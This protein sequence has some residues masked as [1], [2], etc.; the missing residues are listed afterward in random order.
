MILGRMTVDKAVN[1][2]F[3]FITVIN[4]IYIILSQTNHRKVCNQ[5]TSQQHGSRE[6][7]TIKETPQIPFFVK[8]CSD[9]AAFEVR[10]K[11]KVALNMEYV[12][13]L[14][15]AQQDLE[16]VVYTPHVIIL[17]RGKAEA[18]L[19]KDGRMLIKRVSNE[20]EATQVASVIL[21]TALMADLD[22]KQ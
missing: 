9:K 19:S 6:K 21:R 13:Q 18:T 12:K 4:L 7:M 5:Q 20:S 3:I 10:L 15:E 2:Y 14:F 11:R 8:L 22:F 16:I 1:K 17:R